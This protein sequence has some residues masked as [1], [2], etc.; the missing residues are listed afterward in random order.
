MIWI[1]IYLLAA[2]GIALLAYGHLIVR[3]DFEDGSSKELQI[4]SWSACFFV[5]LAWPVTL[6]AIGV[7]FVAVYLQNKFG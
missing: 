6:I 4:L 5:G 1:I 2:S 7:T 3:E